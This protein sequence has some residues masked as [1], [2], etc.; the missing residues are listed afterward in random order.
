MT[1][2]KKRNKRYGPLVHQ[3]RHHRKYT[4]FLSGSIVFS[5]V[6]LGIGFFTSIFSN[7]TNQAV[8]GASISN[9]QTA[10]LMPIVEVTIGPTIAPTVTPTNKPTPT[11]TIRPK[12]TPTSIPQQQE[13]TT[14]ATS[15]Q[16]TAEKINDVT[17]R[18]KN[19]KNDD[20]M[21][22]PQDIVN[23]LNSYR[24]ERGKP[25]LTVDGNLA[26][27]AQDRAN[28]FAS[29]GSLDS[30]AGFRNY[31]DN[32]GF[33]KAGFNSLGENSAYI[34]GP[35]NGDKII[36]SI[37]GADSSHDGNQLDNWTHVGVGVNGNA[38]NVN[39]GKNKK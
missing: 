10:L 19:V 25:N 22:S 1:F 7:K 35:M 4:V 39:F 23:A 12:N 21:A 8:L 24:G 20:N 33:D 2:Y 5:S 26:S 29:N 31:M 13:P 30:H 11:P 17:W 37:F 16:Y 32:G 34:S 27:Y 6:V 3:Q 18:V 36:R 15:G 38:V 14:T 9:A 28:L